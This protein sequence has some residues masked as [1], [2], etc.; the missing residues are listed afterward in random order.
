MP[1]LLLAAQSH[2][3]DF[4]SASGTGGGANDSEDEN[5]FDF[6]T[7]NDRFQQRLREAHKHTTDREIEQDLDGHVVGMPESIAS[8]ERERNSLLERVEAAESNVVKLE[9]EMERRQTRRRHEAEVSKLTPE[10]RAQLVKSE[11][12]SS[13]I[14]EEIDLNFIY[15]YTIKLESAAMPKYANDMTSS[16]MLDPSNEMK[17]YVMRTSEVRRQEAFTHITFTETKN[18]VINKEGSL[19]VRRCSLKGETFGQTFSVDFDVTVDKRIINRMSLEVDIEM[20]IVLGGLLE[21]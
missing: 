18:E 16:A 8:L 3:M 14:Y 6:R 12:E 7:T 2:F 1:L 19:P 10:E 15:D 21:Q 5:P 4:F 9:Q 20:Q 13:E 11:Q 17:A